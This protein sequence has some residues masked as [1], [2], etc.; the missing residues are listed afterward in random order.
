MRV[1]AAPEGYQYRV[2]LARSP[3]KEKEEERNAYAACEGY[4][5]DSFDPRDPLCLSLKRRLWRRLWWRLGGGFDGG[6]V[7]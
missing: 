6:S 1:Y 3:E 5:W 7:G 2:S 4:H